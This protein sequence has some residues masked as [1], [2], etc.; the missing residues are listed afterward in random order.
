MAEILPRKIL[1]HASAILY[2]NLAKLRTWS[3]ISSQLSSIYLST[4]IY[5]SLSLSLC[6]PKNMDKKPCN[7]SQDAEVR[8]GPWTMEEDMILINYIA[9]HGEGV[10]NTLAKSAGN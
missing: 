2:K 3:I 1:S 10:W 8:K 4:Q 5:I 7:S 9:N 6:G